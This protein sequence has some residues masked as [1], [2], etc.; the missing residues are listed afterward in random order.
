MS[1]LL[2]LSIG[3]GLVVSLLFT[4]LFGVAAGGMVVPGYVAL[5]L[6]RPLDVAVTI[7]S[8][9]VA[10]LIVRSFASF[11][12]VF[13]RR[14]TVLMILVGYL[15]GMF[16][17]YANLTKASGFDFEVIGYIIPG[18]IAIWFD[19]QGVVETLSSLLTA[20]AVVRLL[21]IIFVGTELWT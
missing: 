11:T 17:R 2:P 6:T 1:E 5:Q 18:L 9:F 3:I 19:R 15:I 16:L 12:V 13:G 4:E 14:R 8:G 20:S 7:G 21:L 10:F